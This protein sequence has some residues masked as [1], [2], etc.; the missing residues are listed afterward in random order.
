MTFRTRPIRKRSPLKLF[1]RIKSG[2]LWLGQ[3]MRKTSGKQR[4]YAVGFVLVVIATIIVTKVMASAYYAIKNF[5]MGAIASAVGQELKKDEKGYT[6]IVLLGDGGHERDGADLIDTI[7]VASIDY[8]KNAVSMLSI[9][10]DYYVSG[11]G[12]RS[13]RINEL[14][15]N[16][17]NS[18][19]EEKAYELFQTVTGKIVN[20]DIQYYARV[21]FNGFV[22]AV[23]SL[24]GIDVDVKEAIYDPTYPNE[25]DDGYTLFQIEAGPQHLDGEMALKFVRS[26][27]TTSDFSRAARQQQ[28]IE[29][30]RA[31][32]LTAEVLTSP[33]KLKD[34]YNAVSSNMNTDMSVMEMITLAGFASQ[35]DRSH[36]ITK[37]IHDDPGQDGGFLYTPE[38]KLFNDQFV[39]IPFG[40]NLDLIHKY[41]DLIFNQREVLWEPARI[42]VLSAVKTPSVARN[43]GYQLN[44]YGF[45]IVNIDN[46]KD[47]NGER[48]YLPVST[49]RYYDWQTDED[50]L[51]K[52]AHQPTINALDG[53]I[54][55]ADESSDLLSSGADLSI[56]LG[57]DYN[58]LF[59]Q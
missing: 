35:F 21:D 48:V 29:A 53:F 22:Q 2:L 59:A 47:E 36:L 17:K 19:G 38:R 25:T 11:E 24:G 55:A 4:S 58:G 28:V 45:N 52:V 16:H 46:L 41:A 26:R 8:A 6:N 10:R 9:P 56:V 3:L 18:L 27:K 33:G 13:G 7:I 14:Y 51:I 31:K 32:A 15:R 40:D 42:E 44:R 1:R 54:K 49:I 37:V 5:S 50:G 43:T 23:D 34:L 20:L 39:L 30:I 57:D 12:L